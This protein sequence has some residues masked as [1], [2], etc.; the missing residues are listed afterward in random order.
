[1]NIENNNDIVRAV[2][3]RHI[4]IKLNNNVKFEKLNGMKRPDL[5]LT[6]LL[7]AIIDGTL[8]PLSIARIC[9]DKYNK[10][11]KKF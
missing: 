9:D 3:L 8:R 11:L 7:K 10:W 6:A 4:N 1:L 5:Y 2:N